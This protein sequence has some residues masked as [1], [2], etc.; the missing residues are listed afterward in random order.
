MKIVNSIYL[1]IFFFYVFL[2][3]VF[4]CLYCDK[5]FYVENIATYLKKMQYMK[6]IYLNIVFK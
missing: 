3:V 6:T 4:I 1:G 2:L 5:M